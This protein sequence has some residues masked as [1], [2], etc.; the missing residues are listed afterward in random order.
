[1]NIRNSLQN[2]VQYITEAFARIFGPSDDEYPQVGE[3]P[4]EGEPYQKTG[5]PEDV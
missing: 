5:T 3:Q 4:F 1:M 2:L